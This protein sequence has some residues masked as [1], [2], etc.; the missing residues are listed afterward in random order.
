MPIV[1]LPETLIVEPK[2]AAPVE[3]SVATV[4]F[5]EPVALVKVKPASVETPV[6]F[7]V[8]CRVV[9]P[10]ATSVATLVV[11]ETERFVVEALVI[12]AAVIC[13]VFKFA[14]PVTCRL[15]LLT[16]PRVVWPVTFN[17]PPT[18]WLLVTC[19]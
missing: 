9:A 19:R 1:A 16:L 14:L 4:R 15:V 7:S 2:T 3:L 5:P 18:A 12:C 13:A 10:E 11:P 17:V 8:D 6:T